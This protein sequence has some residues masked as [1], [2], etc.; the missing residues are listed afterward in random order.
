MMLVLVRLDFEL[1]DVYDERR[2]GTGV[3]KKEACHILGVSRT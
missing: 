3:E 1:M 2:F